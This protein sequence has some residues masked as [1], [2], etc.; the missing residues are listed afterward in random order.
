M[1]RKID[2]YGKRFG[3]LVVIG[4]AVKNK[5]GQRQVLCQCDCGNKKAVIGSLLNNGTTKSCGCF[6]IDRIKETKTRHGHATKGQVS[7]TF[8]TW[9]SIIDRCTNE[10]A[11]GYAKYGAKG[12]TVCERWLEKF[13]NFLEDMGEKPSP[14]HS[15]DRINP[16]AGY[17]PDN[18]RWATMKEQ[19]NNRT[20]NRL[21]F[22]NG[23][24]K[25]LM[26]WADDLKMSH[27][28]IL[29]RIA[30]GLSPEEAVTEQRAKEKTVPIMLDV[31]GESISIMDLS[32]KTG[33]NKGTL[34]HRIFKIGMSPSDAISIP[35]RPW[36]SKKLTAVKRID[37]EVFDD[38]DFSSADF[39]S[40]SEFG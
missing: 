12:I 31:N 5:H 35:I 16:K 36:R 7:S 40:D 17:S 23:Q 1:N 26:Q 25:T 13:E 21:I 8:R 19:Q 33:I 24:T 2:F 22:A 38:D 15:I 14:K 34:L 9:W 11:S 29:G 3:R 10:K 39:R 28:S 32:R 27:S 18:C 37:L 6:K 30:R 20:N 4:E